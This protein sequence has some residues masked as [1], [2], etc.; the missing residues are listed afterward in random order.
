MKVMV[1][2]SDR[3]LLAFL[4]L[5][6]LSGCHDVEQWYA[7]TPAMISL[8]RT[9]V[10]VLLCDLGLP[11]VDG[12]VVARAAALVPQPPRIVLMSG[13]PVRLEQA[14]PLASSVLHK[15]FAAAQLLQ[16][17]EQLGPRV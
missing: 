12:E 3:D 4:G 17:L 1:V 14:R 8:Q 6:I 9:S 2:E 7:G 5:V 10:D 13:E 11:D 16:L 15:P